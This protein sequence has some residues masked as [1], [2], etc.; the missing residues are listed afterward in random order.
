MFLQ[1]RVL[2][3]FFANKP[4]VVK[5]KLIVFAL[6]ILQGCQI[7]I[8]RKNVKVISSD[9][10]CCVKQSEQDQE[11]DC[12][13]PAH[14]RTLG[15]E[16]AYLTA[17]RPIKTNAAN[18]EIRGGEYV[19]YDRANYESALTIWL[20]HAKEGD[21]EA[22]MRVGEIYEKGMGRSP[23][24]KL[25]RKW[26]NKAT[27]QGNADALAQLR[28]L[29]ATAGSINLEKGHVKI[30]NSKITKSGQKNKPSLARVVPVVK[31]KDLPELPEKPR[32][33]TIKS[34]QT[35]IEEYLNT[36][37]QAAYVF[38]P[39]SPI[40][41]AR[42]T[43]I[44]LLI[45]PQNEKLALEKHLKK[46]DPQNTS[47]IESDTAKWAQVMEAGL[48]GGDFDIDPSTPVRKTLNSSEIAKWS[49]VITPKH[50]GAKLPLNLTV[51]AI[52]PNEFAPPYDVVLLYKKIDVKVTI[53]WLIDHYFDKYWK[54]L[55]GGLAGL[56]T[57]MISLKWKA[58][59]FVTKRIPFKRKHLSR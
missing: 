31:T 7:E 57:G 9:Q 40:K 3:I 58:R 59:G 12:L 13:L 45:D 8:V 25:A 16:M 17:R 11:V 14:I 54:W 51:K 24:L 23:N 43:I 1:L 44:Y 49:W 33:D 46:L 41:V 36:L 53:W 48:S 18:C 52:L 42:P 27:E 30:V 29:Q 4:L 35:R 6:I 2:S 37:K 22:Q 26:Y 55:L 28:H 39:P 15:K 34:F 20:P 50:P 19:P 10:D 5:Y 21:A 38:N 47:R 56:I 32:S